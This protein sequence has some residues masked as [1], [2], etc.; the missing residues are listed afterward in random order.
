MTT[1]VS[2]F[3]DITPDQTIANHPTFWTGPSGEQTTGNDIATHL[4]AAL[5]LLETRG[6][7]RN[8]DDPDPELPDADESMSVKTILLSLLRA[9]RSMTTDRGP[10]TLTSALN[11]TQDTAGDQD[12]R[13]IADQ[14]M[15]ALVS[16]HTGTS[17]A[18]HGA[19]VAKR[20][21]TWHEVRD[22]L[23]A[24]SAFARAYGPSA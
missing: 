18:L 8:N 17:H 3:A 9:A 1:T 6:W 23:T 13:W 5:A 7:S 11:R 15:N 22:L 2:S 21:R 24:A 12:T 16:A 19:W 10:L 4:D 20:T 14:V